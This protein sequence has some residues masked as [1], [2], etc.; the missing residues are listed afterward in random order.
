MR[1]TVF[2][3]DRDK[4]LL[5]AVENLFPKALHSYYCQH[6]ANN[7]HVRYEKDA[8]SLFWPIARARS[9]VALKAAIQALKDYNTLAKEYLAKLGYNNFCFLSFPGARFG[10]D[11][12]NVTESLNSIWGEICNLPPL[13]M[14]KQIYRYLMTLYHTRKGKKITN[15]SNKTFTNK[16]YAAY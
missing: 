13:Q 12:N 11:I 8:Y 10:H 15:S 5:A 9:R 16:V 1:T 7:I 3:S 4:G 2:I 14:I 6:I